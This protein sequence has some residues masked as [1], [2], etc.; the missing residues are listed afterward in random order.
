MIKIALCFYG[1]PRY[2]DNT[3]VP[4]SYAKFFNNPDYHVEAFGHCWYSNKVVYSSSSWTQKHE[5]CVADDNAISTLYKYYNFSKLLVEKPRTF[6]FNNPEFKEKYKQVQHH[7][8]HTDQRE[9]NTLSQLYSIEMA[10]KLAPDN[11]DYYVLCRY[12]TVLTGIPDFNL[13]NPNTLYLPDCGIFSDIVIIMGKKYLPWTRSNYTLAQEK[14]FPIEGF[15][16]EEFKKQ[17]FFDHGFDYS[18]TQLVN[19]FGNIV[20]NSY[21]ENNLSQR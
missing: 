11:F 20:R 5:D 8:N 12:D 10:T 18:E 15:M 14:Y 4:K 9:N 17:C 6:S 13:L 21:H 3:E 19:M 2:V 16:P 1:Q 7:I